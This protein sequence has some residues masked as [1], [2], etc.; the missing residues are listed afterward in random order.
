MYIIH[1]QMDSFEEN[2]DLS[3][4]EKCYYNHLRANREWASRNPDKIKAYTKKYQ[5]QKYAENPKKVALTRV[6]YN[7]KY[8]QKKKAKLIVAAT[9]V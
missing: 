1:R 6:E 4:A 2:K 7:K 9:I 3:P 5:E 8:Y